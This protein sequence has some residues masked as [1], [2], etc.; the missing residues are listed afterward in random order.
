M[1]SRYE[2]AT[3]SR[4]QLRAEVE[5]I[6]PRVERPTRY[7]GNEVNAIRKD[8]AKAGVSVCLCF[9]ELYEVGMSWPGLQIL[10]HILNTHP[11]VVAERAYS[12]WID[13][14]KEMRA[15]RV[16]AF[17]LESWSPLSSFDVL[18]FTLQYELTFT[19]LLN[20]LDLAGIPK[21]SADRRRD[22]PVV[23]AGGPVSYNCEPIA[24]FLDAICLGD[25]EEGIL[26]VCNAV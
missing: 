19:N 20:V 3:M 4:D 18:G 24:D 13:M 7:L 9:P 26:E 6:L 15:A 12:P 2:P 22:D 25:G 8:P 11:G 21:R 16:P 17:S 5:T 10:Y 1:P 23:I 14:E